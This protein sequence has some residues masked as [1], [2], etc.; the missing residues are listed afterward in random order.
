MLSVSPIYGSLLVALLI[1]LAYRVTTFRRGE[2][3]ALGDEKGSWEMKRAI[4]AHAN[5]MENIPAAL[6]LLVMLEINQLNPIFLHILGAGFLVARVLHAKGISQK[7]GPSF[8]RFYGTIL[9]WLAMLTMV[10]L[11]I[12][13]VVTG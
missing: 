10:V 7:S 6:I 5:A 1:F 9:T 12:L 4:R 3:I 13:I 8:G 2:S 11:N